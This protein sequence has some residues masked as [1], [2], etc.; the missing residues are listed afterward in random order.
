MISCEEAK[1]ISCKDES[2]Y[3]PI[4]DDSEYILSIIDTLIR[5]EASLGETDLC[6][7]LNKFPIRLTEFQMFVWQKVYDKLKE[8]QF[9]VSYNN[10]NKE[11]NINWWK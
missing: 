2:G 9:E 11:L 1:K 8:N 3:N 5:Y 6:I 4:R 10:E 7:C